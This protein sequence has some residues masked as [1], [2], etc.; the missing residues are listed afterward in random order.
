MKQILQNLKIGEM[1]LTDV[2]CP[3]AGSG[4]VLI[5][6][7]ASLISAGTER[8]LV[9]F[10][11]ANLIQKARQQPEKVKQVLDKMKTDGLMPTLDAVFRKL[12]EPMPLGYC[13]AGRVVQAQGSKLKEKI[14][15]ILAAD[16]RRLTQT[17]HLRTSQVKESLRFATRMVKIM[18]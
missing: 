11:Q 2:P 14:K 12:D 13:N 1:E 5:Q 17:F 10:S 7:R 16:T 3:Q 15:N 9:E 6:T 8:M 4:R 18:Q